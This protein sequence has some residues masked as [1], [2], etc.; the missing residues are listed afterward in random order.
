[1]PKF[2]VGQTLETDV[3]KVEVDPPHPVGTAMEFQVEVI[4]T[5]GA[6]ATANITI[7]VAPR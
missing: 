1:M 5:L 4:D 6:S 3:P 2:V 7:K